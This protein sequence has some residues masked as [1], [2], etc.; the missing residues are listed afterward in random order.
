MA[1]Q[2]EWIEGFRAKGHKMH[3]VDDGLADDTSFD[4]GAN[5]EPA[6]AF[7]DLRLSRDNPRA[8]VSAVKLRV[9]ASGELDGREHSALYLKLLAA[10]DRAT[11]K[12]ARATGDHAA[13][14]ARNAEG[15]A[16]VRAANA[17]G[18]VARAARYE[19]ELS[20][21]RD[22]SRAATPAADSYEHEL[23]VM[24]GKRGNPAPAAQRGALVELGVLTGLKVGPRELRWSLR[25]APVLA[26]D[27]DKRLHLVY[28][29]GRVERASSP[30]EVKEYAR[31]HWG[32]EG[33]GDVRGGGLA[34]PAFVDV[35]PATSITYTTKKGVDR[36]LVDYVH[37]FGEGSSRRCVF[38]RVLEHRCAGGC[39][40]RCAARGSLRLDGGSYTV[41]DRGI[42]G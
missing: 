38:P 41:E 1:L 27:A 18:D 24:R 16:E 39:S 42:V 34:P 33:R 26:Y 9:L 12:E 20:A 11:D 7:D 4:F 30:A 28:A 23:A 40:P 17:A 5:A 25:G 2:A 10:V 29:V 31:K 14:N 3:N 13:A 15:R 19:R 6:G 35:G 32:N 21:L 8:L 22:K 37:P 36:K